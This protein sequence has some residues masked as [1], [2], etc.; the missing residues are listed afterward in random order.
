MTTKKEA[1][2]A[3]APQPPAE[4]DDQPG[5]EQVQVVQTT[6]EPVRY[7][8]HVLTDNGWVPEDN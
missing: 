4:H 6:E 2:P 7:G 3:A 8:G 5:S 1:K